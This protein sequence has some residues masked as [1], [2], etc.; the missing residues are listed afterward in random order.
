MILPAASLAC[1]AFFAPGMGKVPLQMHQLIAT[2]EHKEE[3]P[4]T[5]AFMN[6]MCR[7]AMLASFVLA[8]PP[9]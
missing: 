7:G 2:C 1:F 9:R 8:N 5:A 4:V 3:H 6:K